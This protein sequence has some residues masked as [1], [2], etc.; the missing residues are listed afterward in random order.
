MLGLVNRGLES[1]VRDLHGE[2][3][4]HEIRSRVPNAP[5]KF[6]ALLQ[7]PWAVTAGLIAGVAEYSNVSEDEILEDLGTYA[8]T[9]LWDSKLRRIFLFC[10]GCFDEFLHGLGDLFRALE[11]THSA[12]VAKSWT[13]K[14]EGS[15]IYFLVYSGSLNGLG[16]V[17]SG[18]LRSLADQYG[19]LA[20]LTHH[21]PSGGPAR[22]VFEITIHNDPRAV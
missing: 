17:V 5:E 15:G 18:I 19:A 3:A 21:M 16:P 7:Y 11:D 20:T 8:V 9:D 2:T 14:S 10:G 6:E 4:W 12:F 13:L 22:E 1:F